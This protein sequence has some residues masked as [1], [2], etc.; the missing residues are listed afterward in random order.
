MLKKIGVLGLGFA[1]SCGCSSADESAATRTQSTLAPGACANHGLQVTDIH[2]DFRDIWKGLEV[3]ATG[4]Q[5]SSNA[6]VLLTFSASVQ[7]A[8]MVGSFSPVITDGSCGK[9]I[10]SAREHRHHVALGQR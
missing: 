6:S 8:S 1:L 3:P 2:A 7:P 10:P 5:A 4:K 9:P